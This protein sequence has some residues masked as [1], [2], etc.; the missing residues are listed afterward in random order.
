MNLKTTTWTLFYY[1]RFKHSGVSILYTFYCPLIS[2]V[3]LEGNKH[4]FC[5]EMTLKMCQNL[6]NVD[7]TELRERKRRMVDSFVFQYEMPSIS[8]KNF[9]LNQLVTE[10][11][12]KAKT[13]Q[14]KEYDQKSTKLKTE[15]QNKNSMKS[16]G[17][18]MWLEGNNH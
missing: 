18:S 15:Q 6:W 5:S 14:G 2:I 7:K 13:S 10:E 12:V 8:R 3:Y 17:C 4:L 11:P 1:Y 9:C 16:K